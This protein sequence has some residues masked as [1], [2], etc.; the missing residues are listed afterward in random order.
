MRDTF[1]IEGLRELE[2]TM[3]DL[4]LVTAKSSVRRVLKKAAQ[5]IAD[6]AEANA[7]EDEGLLR[8]SYGVGSRL[9]K[10]QRQVSPKESEVEVFVGPGSKGAGR[11]MQ[12][13]FGNNHQAAQ[14]HLRPA[15]DEHNSETLEIV[16]GEIWSDVAKTVA[17]HRNR[18][19]KKGGR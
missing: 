3:M 19:A 1:K 12:T 13:E 6:T 2:R 14:P 16:K 4:P 10:S 15:W 18:I 7:P 5:P 9:T 17:R 11:G 8:E